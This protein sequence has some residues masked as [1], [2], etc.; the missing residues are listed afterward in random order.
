MLAQHLQQ[1]QQQLVTTQVKRDQLVA[2]G[3]EHVTLLRHVSA[4][5]I[6]RNRTQRSSYVIKVAYTRVK[7]TGVRIA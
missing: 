7:F 6:T 5:S 3:G 4:G 2:A 1:Q